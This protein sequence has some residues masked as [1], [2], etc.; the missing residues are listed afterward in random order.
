M[1]M[2]PVTPVTLDL[3]Q[4]LN[5]GVRPEFQEYA[6]FL[7][8]GDPDKKP[9]IVSRDEAALE[10]RELMVIVQIGYYQQT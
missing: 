6:T 9:Q 2:I 8:W 7:L 10:S 1:Y 5:D 3:I 4:A